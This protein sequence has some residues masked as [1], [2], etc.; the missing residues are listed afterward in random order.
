MLCLAVWL[1]CAQ[2]SDAARC[3]GASRAAW[4]FGNKSCPPAQGVVNAETCWMA[5][6]LTIKS[7]ELQDQA[8][9]AIA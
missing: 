2:H 4:I 1:P 8:A 9:C 6:A 7:K 3:S 5:A